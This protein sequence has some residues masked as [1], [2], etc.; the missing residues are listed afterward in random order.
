MGKLKPSTIRIGRRYRENRLDG[1]YD[2]VIIGSGI[3]G[4]T[5]AALLSDLGWKVCVLEQHYTAGGYTHSYDRNGY[6]WD[7]GVHYIGD[8]G[9]KTRTRMMFDY[10]SGGKLKWAPMDEEYDRFYVGSKTFCAKAGKQQFR[11][12]LVSQFPAEEQAIDQY[13]NLLGQVGKGLTAYSMKKLLKPWQRVVAWP[14]LKLKIPAL[15]F[16]NTY[17]VLSELTNDQDLIAVICGQWGDMGLPPKRSAFMVHAMIA[18]HYLHGGFYPIGGS[19][20]I[21]ETI[22]PKI[23]RTG[24]EVFTYAL[25]EQILLQGQQ[26]TGVKMADGH[27]IECDHVIS[28]AGIDNTFSRLLP[29]EAV[30]NAGYDPLLKRVQPSMA[31]LGV[32]IGLKE[33]ADQ[34]GLPKTNFWI[35][36]G[37]DSDA[38]VD[39]F[40][41]DSGAPFPVVYISFPSAKD[42]DYSRRHPGTATIEIVAPAP[43]EWFEKWRGT[44]WGK[45]GDDYDTFKAELGDRLMQYLYEKLPQLKGKVDYYEVSTPLSTE[46][47]CAYQYGELY[48]LDHDSVRLQQTWLGPRTRFKGLWLTGQDVLTCGVTGAMMAGLLTTSAM[49][50]MRKSGTLLKKIFN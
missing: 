42:P 43:L 44:I 3:G 11:D 19:W 48:G 9:A 35:Y 34:L 49:I 25:V 18:R 21:A 24:G 38:A 46:Y 37:N 5:T 4:L 22:I 36:P 31:H 45:R 6:E 2:A 26:V 7:V 47:F 1:P 50:G 40:M 33:T 27:H 23:Q 29:A 12:N 20:N 14:Y 41:K 16:R 13:M 10:L 39:G 30:T 28:S 15:L 8:V 32:Y 17:E